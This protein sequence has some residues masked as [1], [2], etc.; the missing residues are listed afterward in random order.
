M[1]KILGL[2]LAASVGIAAG[3]L[4][5]QAAEDH[6][7][8]LVQLIRQQDGKLCA[9]AVDKLITFNMSPEWW[10]F[11]LKEET[12][13]YHTLRILGDALMTF[14][15][16]EGGDD[17]PKLDQSRDASSP[18]VT[19][20]IDK[21]ASKAHITIDFTQPVTDKFMKTVQH[22]LDLV[23]N[24]I[25]DTNYCK[26]RGHKINVTISIDT[27]AKALGSTVSKDG[28]DYHLLLPAYMDISTMPIEAAFKKGT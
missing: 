23:A 21:L 19:D 8:E 11:F 12:H 4:P 22:N 17:I 28:N 13:G 24:P 9:L 10:Q 2:F 15:N 16:N 14:G 18:L 3:V 26:P 27:K 25:T 1:R 20:A 6:K 5:G 7:A